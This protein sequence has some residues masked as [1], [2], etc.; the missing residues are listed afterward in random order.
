MIENDIIKTDSDK[1]ESQNKLLLKAFVENKGKHKGNSKVL[2]QIVRINIPIVL[3]TVSNFGVSRGSSF[4]DD[5]VAEGLLALFQ[6]IRKYDKKKGK[7]STYAFAIVRY[8]LL[9]LFSR[10]NSCVR[11]PSNKYL[12]LRKL[13]KSSFAENREFSEEEKELFK[14]NFKYVRDNYDQEEFP[15]KDIFFDAEKHQ[16][17]VR[18]ADEKRYAKDWYNALMPLLKK[19]DEREQL[20]LNKLFGFGQ[21]PENISNISKGIGVSTERTRQIKEKALRKLKRMMAG[22]KMLIEEKYDAGNGFEFTR[23]KIN[24]ML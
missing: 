15:N 22:K 9:G 7:F 1:F 4:Y 11:L 6:S 21:E 10:Y 24:A 8:K 14:L 20:V 23:H 19:L 13:I 16:E 12:K 18:T 5:F 3:Q 17:A 2:D